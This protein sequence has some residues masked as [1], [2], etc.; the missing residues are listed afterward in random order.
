MKRYIAPLLAALA[1]SLPLGADSG[2]PDE[3]ELQTIGMATIATGET[4]EGVLIEELS[5]I[6]YDRF[7][8]I[9]YAVN[10]SG[11]AGNARLFAFEFDYDSSG[12]TGVTALGSEQL[13]YPN[14]NV[15]RS[16]DAESVALGQN[17]RFYVSTEGRG[18][19]NPHPDTRDPWVW[20]FDASNLQ[21]TAILPVPQKFLP[22]DANGDPIAP[23][24]ESQ[25]TGVRQNLGFEGLGLCPS[26]R[27][28]YVIN[29]AA[30][31]Q[32]D[33]RAPFD[34]ELNQAN[35]S[36]SRLLR[37]HRD[38]E[39]DW[40]AGPEKVY[41]SDQGTLFFFVRRFNTITSI[42]PIDDQGRMLVMERGLAA[43]NLNTGSYRIRIYEVDFNQANATDVSPYP[44]LLDLPTPLVL[45]RLSKRLVWQSSSGMDNME[46]MTWGRDLNGYRSVVLVSDNNNST[47]QITQ[48]IAL[49]SNIPAPVRLTV[50]TAGPGTVTTHPQLTDYLPGISLELTAVP[51]P[52]RVFIRWYG[53]IE[54]T[55]PQIT[56]TP[57]AGDSEFSI[58]AQFGT[59]FEGWLR[60]YYSE[61]QI[62]ATDLEDPTLDPLHDGVPN[63]LKYALGLSPLQGAYGTLTQTKIED[64]ILQMPVFE[65]IRPE[66]Q[67]DGVSYALG[68]SQNL[69]SDWTTYPLE[70][71]NGIVVLPQD[72]DTS[73]IQ[74]PSPH[75]LIES[76][77]QFMR[78]EVTTNP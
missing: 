59:P 57:Q 9:F 29:E 31:L 25:A 78:L 36:D 38:E 27:F 53:T 19:G 28:V 75:S 14:G 76:P 3:V 73:L 32:D 60:N 26:E 54:S 17:D 4:I 10:D 35:N 12:V 37:F 58:N 20:E 45:N 13:R 2:I 44:S 56:L 71:Y 69:G 74:V 47:D 41:R 50:D 65:F 51:E 43:N 64:E 33:S 72:D 67:P 77:R 39:G 42:L 40:Q 24:E 18:S 52:N 8:D 49:Q 23:G 68:F 11:G 16:V 46:G 55:E 48:F 70:N 15:L 62:A 22:R 34:G 21:R 7:E 63:L 30:L 61:E 1:P 5:G 6:T 66:P